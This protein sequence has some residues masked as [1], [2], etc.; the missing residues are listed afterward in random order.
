M[1]GGKSKP[2]MGEVTERGG[3]TRMKRREGSEGVG[4]PVLPE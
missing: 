1:P 3:W 2:R 4:I